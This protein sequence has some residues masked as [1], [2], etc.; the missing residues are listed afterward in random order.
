MIIKD[1]R[2]EHMGQYEY[3][4]DNEGHYVCNYDVMGSRVTVSHTPAPELMLG[5]KIIKTPRTVKSTIS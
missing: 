2:E 5:C 4:F 1:E 3:H